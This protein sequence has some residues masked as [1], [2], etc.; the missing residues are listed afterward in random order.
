MKQRILEISQEATEWRRTLHRHPQTAYEELFASDF[1]A[2]KLDAW[3]IPYERKWA[4]TGIVATL[5]GEKNESGRT[6]GIRADIDALDIKESPNKPWISETEGKMHGCGHDGHTS[7]L[8][9]TAQYLS[10]TRN[11]DG[12]VYLIFQ[13]AEEGGNDIDHRVGAERMIDEGLFKKY[14]MDAV[15]ALHNWPWLPKG[16]IA[17]CPGPI[18]ASSDRFTLTIQGVGG[19]AAMPHKTKDPIVAAANAVLSVQNFVSRELDPLGTAVIS[20]TNLNAG[21]GAF[22][23]IPDKAIL[24]GSIRTLYPEIRDRIEKRLEEI[25]NGISHIYNVEVNFKYNRIVDPTINNAEQVALCASVAEEILGSSNVDSN[26]APAMASEDFGAMLREVPGCY[27][28]LGQN[29]GEDDKPCNNSLHTPHYDFNDDVIPIGTE[30]WIK[31][32]ER[33]LKL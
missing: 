24:E 11:F 27:L 5:T 21:T 10:E 28:W 23:V 32:V 29:T 18:M 33:S 17:M 22:N 7:M 12:T 6:I 31:L 25:F 15:F 13:P 9:A 14:K 2:Q 30:F 3:N 16:Q 8:L 26:V 4:G 19:H 1:I 20:I